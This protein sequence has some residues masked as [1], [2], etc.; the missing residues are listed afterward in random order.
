[1]K[2][3]INAMTALLRECATK[4]T[5]FS[6]ELEN[7]A[8]PKKTYTFDEVRQTCALKSRDGHTEEVKDAIAKFGASTLSGI[9][10]KDYSALMAIVEGL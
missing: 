2:E 3:K 4:L 7:Y 6:T 1:M 9:D 10:P 5:E 8:V